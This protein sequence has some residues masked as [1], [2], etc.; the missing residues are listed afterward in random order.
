MLELESLEGQRGRSLTLSVPPDEVVP[1]P[2]EAPGLD[3]NGIES[4]TVWARL[5]GILASTLVRGSDLLTGARLGRVVVEAYQLAPALRLLRKPRPCLLIADDVGLGKTIEAGLAMLELIARRRA[6]RI[7][8]VAPPGLLLQWQAELLHKFGLEFHLI[9]NAAGFA[10]EQTV[11]PSGVNP[12]DGLPRVL[13]SVDFL[14]KETVRKRALRKRWDLVIV[15]EAH[16]LAEAGTSANPYRTQRTR[17]GLAL[18]DVARGLV[19]LTATPHNGHSHSFRSLLEL[20]EPTLA[21][22]RGA[23]PDR[24]RRIE[25]ARIRRMKSQITRVKDGRVEPVFPERDVSGIPT[26]TDARWQEV[27]RKVSGYCSRT[28]RSARDTEDDELVT[29]AMQIVKKRALS[30]RRA[31]EKTIEN[32]LR[33]LR[34]KEESGPKPERAEIREYQADLPMTEAAAER[35]AMRIVKSAVPREEKL[36]KAEVRALNGIAKLLKSL[37]D[38][39]PKI[40][41]LLQ[42]LRGILDEDPEAKVIVFTEY[43]DTLSALREAFESEPS[44]SGK[45]VEIRG[46]MSARQRVRVQAK[47][48]G[49]G[50][51][52]LL[53]TDAASEGLNLQEACHRI[54]HFELPW[55]PNRLEQRNG[56]V[57]RYGQTKE[58][59]GRYLFY[60]ESPEEDV[61]HRL[62]ERI[63]AM[64]SD[65]ISTPDILGV[66]TGTSLLDSDLVELDGEAKDVEER[67]S[68]LV[69][70]FEDRT[71][72]FV[73][74]VQPL[75]AARADDRAELQAILDQ[76]DRAHSLSSDDS[77]LEQLVAGLFGQSRVQQTSDE[78]ILRIEVP[79]HFRGPR[80]EPVYL[81]ATF[82]R[83]VA[84]KHRPEE[85]DFVTAVHPL[86]EAVAGE[87]RRRL[88]HVYSD[89]RGAQARRLSVR[90]IPIGEPASA[91]FTFL[92][93]IDGAEGLL[94]EDVLALRIGSDLWTLGSPDEALRWIDPAS[95]PGEVPFALVERLFSRSFA[96]MSEAASEAATA[97]LSQRVM[98]LREVRRRQAELL[99]SELGRDL[100]DRL[101]EIDEEERR[102]RE[103]VDTAGQGMLF[104]RSTASLP[105]LDQ[106]RAAARSQ[107][108]T[109]LAELTS[110]EAVRDPGPARPL[111]VLF[112]VPEDAR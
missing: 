109:R 71:A 21:T 89:D 48:E 108:E 67:K 11:L 38:G 42:E 86:V 73:R 99:R 28:A 23:A 35:T 64:Q 82:R 16:G 98:S 1:L 34:G 5:H 84:V 7:L 18:R 56:R 39:D 33:V 80:V 106:R 15:D 68:S 52:V 12:W 111:G 2:S 19:L 65:R 31:F 32:R 93:T 3:R 44:L 69:K 17:L 29:F 70:I 61:L 100:S 40:A 59:W 81:R 47:F 88:L 102:A 27:F 60:P 62:I 46:G 26:R 101:Q 66:L 8:V 53:A 96:G 50:T 20:V 58:P 77:G 79:P 72:E 57:D 105:S 103:L 112:L 51:N 37:P 87:A 110:F 54:I 95:P 76:L 9:E 83:S 104:A 13:T 36:R 10:R 24:V 75:V 4:F 74:D 45:T 43:L 90:R 107:A 25:S 63:Q 55:N 14:K 49:P 97:L 6:D 92:G 22:F 78:G 85:V 41:R 94:E 91:V 30:S